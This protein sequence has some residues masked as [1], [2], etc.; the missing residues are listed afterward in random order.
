MEGARRWLTDAPAYPA[1]EADRREID[2]LGL[3]LPLRAA[4]A[5]AVVTIVLLA[6]YSRTFLPADLAAMGRAPSALR[7]V[8]IERAVLFGLLPLAVVLFAFRDRP[9]RYGIALGDARTGLT[10]MFLGCALMTPIVLWFAT[11]PD[12]RAYYAPSTEPLPGLVLTNTLDLAASEF[13]FRGFLTFTLLRALGPVG[14]LVATMPFVYAHLGKPELELFSTLAGGLVYG[15]LAWRTR[16]I[17]WGTIGHV[18]ILSL[19]IS[20]AGAAGATTPP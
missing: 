5:I 6:D 17:L 3:R 13:L 19:V 10:L 8:A 11:L 9:S 1:G 4:V 14:V 18:Y 12:V 2:L 15:W 16:S 20:V 7:I